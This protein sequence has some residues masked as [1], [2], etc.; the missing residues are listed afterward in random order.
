MA[1]C[2]R[3][4]AP[5]IVPLPVCKVVPRNE[6]RRTGPVAH[7]VPPE[8]RL[9][10]QFVR[11]LVHVRLQVLVRL[12]DLA[13]A[14]LA[15]ELG[16]VLHDERVGRQVIRM[17]RDRVLER[18]APVIDGLAG[19]SVNQVEADLKARL[20]RPLHD[21]RN[22]LGIVGAL[23]GR[24]H[25]RHCGLHAEGHPGE[26]RGRERTQVVVIH[27]VGVRLG[28]HLSTRP[29]SPGIGDGGEHRREIG[30]RQHGGRA[31]SEEHRGHL[32]PRQPGPLEHLAGLA[33]FRDRLGRVVAALGSAQLV[34]RVGVEVAVAAAHAAERHVQVN[35]EVALLGPHC[36]GGGQ[37]P[38]QRCRVG[39]GES[40]W[41]DSAS[42]SDRTGR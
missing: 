14:D 27:R 21:Q 29:E 25:V 10:E 39:D 9:P 32:P 18:G 33:Y 31:T 3:P 5:P 24:Q 26:A 36:R 13:A 8:P 35:P 20:P 2:S 19:C 41:H 37:E 34:R 23:Q 22:P 38:V 30:H 15:C 11:E 17:L 16:A 42:R 1:V 4:D 6:L 28:G 12:G 40:G 7:L